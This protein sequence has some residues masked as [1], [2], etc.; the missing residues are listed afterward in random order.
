MLLIY[1]VVLVVFLLSALYHSDVHVPNGHC[2]C[3]DCQ[4]ENKQ[5]S[6]AFV[7]KELIRFNKYASLINIT[8]MHGAAAFSVHECRPIDL[9]GMRCW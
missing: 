9:N 5:V 8:K 4:Y 7:Q 6:M 3:C 2:Y 1:R